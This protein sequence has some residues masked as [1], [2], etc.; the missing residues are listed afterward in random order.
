MQDEIESLKEEFDDRKLDGIINT[1]EAVDKFVVDKLEALSSQLRDKDEE[2]ASLKEQIATL[3]AK[4]DSSNSGD[5][6]LQKII[7]DLRV[8]LDKH[9]S[10]SDI[11]KETIKNLEKSYILSRDSS[12]KNYSDKVKVLPSKNKKPVI[13]NE[14]VLKI[15]SGAYIKVLGRTPFI[16]EFLL[17]LTNDIVEHIKNTFEYKIII[18]D[19]ECLHSREEIYKSLPFRV[20]GGTKKGNT[21]DNTFVYNGTSYVDMRKAFQIDNASLL[22][23]ID[24]SNDKEDY[25]SHTKFDKYV[26]SGEKELLESSNVDR[27]RRIGFGFKNCKYQIEINSN[28]LNGDIFERMYLIGKSSLLPELTT[29]ICSKIKL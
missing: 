9:K 13:T 26:I 23:I 10:D 17:Y 4:V 11:Y 14:S 19:P 6:E 2:N 22:I 24:L 8:E 28:F 15:R 20:Y 16:E 21:V 12:R 25:V 7:A 29:D 1:P 5:E 18:Y 27:N 3:S